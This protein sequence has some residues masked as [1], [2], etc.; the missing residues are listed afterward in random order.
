MRDTPPRK[1]AAPIMA[2]IPGGMISLPVQYVNNT[3]NS[4]PYN[5]PA[6]NAGIIIPDGTFVPKVISN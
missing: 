4:R 2:R 6:S 5:A 1:A 3:P